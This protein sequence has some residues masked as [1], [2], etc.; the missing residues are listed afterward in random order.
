MNVKNWIVLIVHVL[1][2]V[3]GDSA[4]LENIWTKE[5]L[6]KLKQTN[7]DSADFYTCVCQLV[8]QNIKDKNRGNF[9]RASKH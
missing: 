4:S 6:E 2:M 9:H 8:E 5:I 1:R 7:S 3:I